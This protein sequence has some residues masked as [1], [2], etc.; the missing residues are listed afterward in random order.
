MAGAL[1]VIF[2]LVVSIY[3]L[4][5]FHAKTTLDKIADNLSNNI[6]LSYSDEVKLSAALKHNFKELSDNLFI[7]HDRLAPELKVAK[8]AHLKNRQ[9]SLDLLNNIRKMI[10]D[11]LEKSYFILGAIIVILAFLPLTI[12]LFTIFFPD[13]LFQ[14]AIDILKQV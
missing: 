3:A 9:V 6:E 2:G 7:S 1:L 8:I 13:R 12:Y 5:L 10:E 14:N 4:Q 11:G